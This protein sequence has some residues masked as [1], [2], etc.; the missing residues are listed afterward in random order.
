MGAGNVHFD[1][2]PTGRY[3]AGF[4]SAN[5]FP[6]LISIS[7]TGAL[8]GNLM[9]DFGYQPLTG[10]IDASGLF[11]YVI[12]G[13]G[14]HPYQIDPVGFNVNELPAANLG[15]SAGRLVLVGAQ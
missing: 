13:T 5:T 14:V 12:G 4:T 7:S 2:D 3:I 11:S 8:A 15:T 10:M 6:T 9:P 1:V